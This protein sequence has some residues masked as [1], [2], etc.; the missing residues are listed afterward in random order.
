MT[1]DMVKFFNSQTG[2]NLTPIFNQYLRQAELPVLELQFRQKDGTVSYRWK[3]VVKDFAMPVKVG[4]RNDW[5][6]L[7]PTTDWQTMK[8]EL[9]RDE[10]DVATD[11]YY[12][13]VV[14][15]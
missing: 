12:I 5:R 10:F 15:T 9:Q 8:S 7:K 13:E 14:K 11:R 2:I 3:T 6:L 1:E 4:R